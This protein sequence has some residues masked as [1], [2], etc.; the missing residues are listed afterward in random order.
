MSNHVNDLII[1]KSIY[2]A[3]FHFHLSY[4]FSAWGQ[5]LNPKNRINLLQKKAIQINKKTKF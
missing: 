1:I 3:I 2:Y 4:V 5:N